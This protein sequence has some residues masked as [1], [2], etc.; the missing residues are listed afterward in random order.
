MAIT[1]TA[2]NDGLSGDG[3]NVFRF[4]H[5]PWS[6]NGTTLTGA[7]IATKGGIYKTNGLPTPT[8]TQVLSA[9]TVE[10]I[11]GTNDGSNP[12]M[13]HFTRELVLPI[14]V[15]NYVGVIV[16]KSIA[17]NECRNYY[18]YSTDG[19][20]SWNCNTLQYWTYDKIV[21]GY[22]WNLLD[23]D[24]AVG[25][26][27]F[28][29]HKTANT[30]YVSAGIGTAHGKGLWTSTDGGSTWSSQDW[31]WATNSGPRYVV[32]PFADASGSAY[33]NDLKAWK[34]HVE[35]ESYEVLTSTS[36]P[37]P[38]F[39]DKSTWTVAHAMDANVYSWLMD[40]C[41]W[42]ED[43]VYVLTAANGTPA[44]ALVYTNNGGSTWSTKALAH[45]TKLQ[46]LS[47][48]PGNALFCAVGTGL[49]DTADVYVYRTLD[50]GAT[51]EDA[52]GDLNTVFPSSTSI[53]SIV[54]DWIKVSP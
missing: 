1:W 26:F 23:G 19:G 53:R 15:Q 36:F 31:D 4:L 43:Y 13:C 46:S 37:G 33:A 50:G 30:I 18:A 47:A 42:D 20:T 10:G 5:D 11:I 32:L 3:L 21:G 24:G 38:G 54:P 2:I 25:V 28:P 22:A 17:G 7:Y 35:S 8:W 14:N 49:A 9:A 52:T 44:Y 27:A 6:S 29:S 39:I 51:F 41:T 12:T 45:V 40:L 16:R 34:C 48:L